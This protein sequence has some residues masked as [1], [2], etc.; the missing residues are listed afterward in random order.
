[1]G[2]EQGYD[3][4]YSILESTLDM[5][6]L[7]TPPRLNGDRTLPVKPR[8]GMPPLET[9]GSKLMDVVTSSRCRR[10]MQSSCRRWCAE[11]ESWLQGLQP[12][13]PALVLA[14]AFG[15]LGMKL[16]LT[17]RSSTCFKIINR[18]RLRLPPK[19]L[20]RYGKCSTVDA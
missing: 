3:F 2:K 18:S 9:N 6:S 5:Q 16:R 13:M 4:R 15:N 10:C 20:S 12:Q 7:D 14:K 19:D 17:A 1:M 8:C 11:A